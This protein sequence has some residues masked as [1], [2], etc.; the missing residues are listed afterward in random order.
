MN[1]CAITLRRISGQELGDPG[2][3]VADDVLQEFPRQSPNPVFLISEKS[4][5]IARTP[6]FVAVIAFHVY[7]SATEISALN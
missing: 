1:P 4:P 5:G 7:R 2:N 6:Q 3:P